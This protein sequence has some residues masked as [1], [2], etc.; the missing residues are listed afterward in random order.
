MYD[1]VRRR[2]RV[3]LFVASEVIV[4]SQGVE[5]LAGLGEIGLESEDTKGVIGEWNEI[6]IEDLDGTYMLVL[7][8]EG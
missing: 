1:G 2:L 4:G 5:N 8:R 7:E 3:A 6:E